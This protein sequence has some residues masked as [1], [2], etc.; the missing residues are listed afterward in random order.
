MEP[1]RNQRKALER[2]NLKWPLVLVKVDE[3]LWPSRPNGLKEVWRSRRF[4]VQVYQENDGVERLTISRTTALYN[5]WKDGI[6]W[7][8]MQQI[9]YE[10]GR[11]DKDALEVFPA[12]KDVVRVANMRHLW[13]FPDQI[14]FVWR[15][16]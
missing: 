8:D 2:E 5:D 7:D 12:E 16:K 4:L 3:R 1:T 11:G 6:S 14:P 13:V 10:C 15:V 9:K